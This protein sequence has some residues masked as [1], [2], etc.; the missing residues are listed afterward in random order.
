MRVLVAAPYPP[1]PDEAAIVA[2]RHVEALVASGDE[3]EV[4]SPLPSAAGLHGP[5]AGL[6]GAWQLARRSRH[7]DSLH[8]I[9]SRHILF[10]PELPRLRRV[11]EGAAMG[12]A[13]RAWRSTSA[14]LGDLSDVPGGGGGLSGRFVWPAIGTIYVSDDL[15]ANHAVK[16]L[17]FPASRVVVRTSP[18]RSRVPGKLGPP[19]APG[20]GREVAAPPPRVRWAIAP[21]A[22]WEDVMGEIAARA[23][24]ERARVTGDDP[25]DA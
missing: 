17:G 23:A 19:A 13:L 25:S 14:D 10:R 15:V 7:H 9:V 11:L 6:T 22:A 4:I 16:V 2:L 21:G 24:A 1:A 3:V 18:G 20:R 5:L 8:L 12:L